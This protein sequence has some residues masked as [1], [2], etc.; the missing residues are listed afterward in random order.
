M[1]KTK[2][3]LNIIFLFL[4]L[5][6]LFIYISLPEYGEHVLGYYICSNGMLFTVSGILLIYFT[7]CMIKKLQNGALTGEHTNHLKKI[8][9]VYI[10][11]AAGIGLIIY[12][13]VRV[14]FY[15]IA[16]SSD[17][18][19]VITIFF[20]AFILI[21]FLLWLLLF[22]ITK[23]IDTK[24]N[25]SMRNLCVTLLG[26]LLLLFGVIMCS[27]NL[28]KAQKDSVCGRQSM[29][30]HDCYYV[31]SHSKYRGTTYDLS[32]Y[33]ESGHVKFDITGIGEN[34]LEEMEGKNV[35]VSFYP[36]TQCVYS[37]EIVE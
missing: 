12:G 10:V 19:V 24:Y 22:P 18:K 29:I 27:K 20:V 13:I 2:N 1:K 4:T 21:V 16:I 36:N 28:I 15:Y 26:Y 30:I 7:L 34:T 33:C 25:I 14:A 5:G 31:S 37:A 35:R 6:L 32:G 17:E 8:I 9:A 11:T 3:I 23:R